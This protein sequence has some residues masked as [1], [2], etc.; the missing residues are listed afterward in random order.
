MATIGTIKIGGKSIAISDANKSAD[1]VY[2]KLA[3]KGYKTT[4]EE[5]NAQIQN[6]GIKFGDFGDSLAGVTNKNPYQGEIDALKE[7]LTS[8]PLGSTEYNRALESLSKL[9]AIKQDPNEGT[10]Q[11]KDPNARKLIDSLLA[12]KE[13]SRVLKNV[14]EFEPEVSTGPYRSRFFDASLPR[15]DEKGAETPP[16]MIDSLIASV[17]KTPTQKT[18]KMDQLLS[19]MNEYA[20]EKG[21]KQLT[22]A[23]KAAIFKKVPSIYETEESFKQSLT[24]AQKD[25]YDYTMN[26]IDSLSKGYGFD[27]KMLENVMRDIVVSYNPNNQK[28]ERKTNQ[29]IDQSEI[30]KEMKK[31]GLK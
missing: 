27:R 5:V 3:A 2:Q 17:F 11:T 4:P 16:N 14:E 21:G 23:E 25:L 19:G 7:K 10:L 30:E 13:A 9:G 29:L 22:G 24:Q 28:T 8:L 18:R 15:Y 6:A 12:G 31:R 1:E 20:F 26:K